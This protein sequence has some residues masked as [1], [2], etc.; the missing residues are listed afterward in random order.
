[1]IGCGPFSSFLAAEFKRRG[2][3]AI[4]YGGS[5]QILFG[6]RGKRWDKIPEFQKYMNEYWIRPDQDIAPDDKECMDQGDYW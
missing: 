1:M 3:Q 2:K 4:Q 5:L 6:V